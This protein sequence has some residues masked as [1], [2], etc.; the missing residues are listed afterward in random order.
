[1]CFLLAILLFKTIPKCSGEV[2]SRI[3]KGKKA[4]MR[5]RENMCA[6]SSLFGHELEAI[7]F[8]SPLYSQ[9][10]LYYLIQCLQDFIEHNY[11]A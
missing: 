8:D 9:I 10:A 1:M 2:L 6:R 4:I 11:L 7:G 3:L 5:P